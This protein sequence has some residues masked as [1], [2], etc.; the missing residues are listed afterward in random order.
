M[1]VSGVVTDAG[2]PLVG[3]TVAV[4]S[5]KA[6]AMTDANGRYT[7]SVPA[8]AVLV[9]TYT[10]MTTQKI[11]VNGRT[12]IDVLLEDEARRLDDVIVVGYGAVKRSELPVL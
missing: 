6:Y 10:G 3:A 12:T 2:E 4:E 7:I 8:D 5:G 9:F 11:A 1:Q